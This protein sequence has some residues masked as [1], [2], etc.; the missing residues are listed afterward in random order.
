ME[1]LNDLT[2][3]ITFNDVHD[4]INKF[5]SR[6]HYAYQLLSETFDKDEVMNNPSTNRIIMLSTTI[7]ALN[8]LN[9]YTDEKELEAKRQELND[10][11]EDYTPSL[12]KGANDYQRV[13]D[14]LKQ[15]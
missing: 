8:A 9:E 13:F 2:L 5:E 4:L 1:A 12:K 7:V 15:L 10:E 14:L 3:T 11:L 6:R